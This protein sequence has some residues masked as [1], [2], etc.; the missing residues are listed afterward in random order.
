MPGSADWRPALFADDRELPETTGTPPPHVVPPP[1]S[2]ALPVGLAYLVMAIVV[3]MLPQTSAILDALYLRGDDRRAVL[4][5]TDSQAPVSVLGVDTSGLVPAVAGRPYA[6]SLKPVGGVPPY[7]WSPVRDG[8]PRGWKLDAATGELR[9]TPTEARDLAARVKLADARDAGVEWPIALV[10]RPAAARGADWPVITTLALP[11]ATLGQ[12]YQFTVGRTGGQP[13]LFWRIMGKK[14]LPEG[15]GLDPRSGEIRGTPRKAGPFPV[16]IRVVDDRYA[17][18]RTLARWIAPLVVTA[19]C[20]L[21]FLS[22]RRW[23]VGVYA[24][25]IGL[26]AV[27]GFVAALPVSAAALGLQAILCLVGAAHLGKMR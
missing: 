12:P 19:V 13:P 21:G 3:A 7:T 5:V 11:S 15:L 4:A 18:S 6:A 2:L 9:G 22:M 27:G 23:S 1:G 26:Q 14:R 10:V 8:W 24:V 25:L 20:L 16:T 17:S